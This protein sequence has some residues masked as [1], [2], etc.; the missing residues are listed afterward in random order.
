MKTTLHNH[1]DMKESK[2]VPCR[3]SID[4][5]LHSSLEARFNDIMSSSNIDSIEVMK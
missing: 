3:T 2:E 4:E 1:Q 5:L